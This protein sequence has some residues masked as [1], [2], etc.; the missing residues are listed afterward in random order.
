M[1]ARLLRGQ[2]YNFNHGKTKQ[3]SDIPKSVVS[4]DG[5]EWSMPSISYQTERLSKIVAK[6]SAKSARVREVKDDYS[7][8][9]CFKRRKI[10]E[11]QFAAS[12]VKLDL[13]KGGLPF[14]TLHREGNK[15]LELLDPTK[16]NGIK[17]LYAK[18]VSSSPFLTSVFDAESSFSNV[19]ELEQ[20]FTCTYDSYSKPSTTNVSDWGSICSLTSEGENS[21]SSPA[22]D[23]P[24]LLDTVLNQEK[25][26]G[27]SSSI[28]KDAV[29]L[30]GIGGAIHSKRI[31]MREAFVNNNDPR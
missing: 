8:D 18:S 29:S 21:N 28:C 24:P 4:S 20:V 16:S 3:R 14:P 15:R 17:L 23:I 25:S 13:E 1:S 2:N 31:S 7:Y 19:Y 11:L 6:A 22:F 26:S 30:D 12:R 9:G 5:E 27:N 10:D